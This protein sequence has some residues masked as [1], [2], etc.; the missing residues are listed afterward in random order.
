MSLDYGINF[1]F[2]M[3]EPSFFFSSLLLLLFFF[4]FERHLL[5]ILNALVI[6]R[7]KQ[8]IEKWSIRLN[9]HVLK[10][11]VLLGCFALK[12]SIRKIRY[13]IHLRSFEVGLESL[14]W[15]VFNESHILF[16][17]FTLTKETFFFSF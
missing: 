9:I 11:L 5:V 17:F 15:V 7:E 1:N 2:V 10:K 16:S 6:G 12:G 13:P 3:L 14:D 4:F 8:E